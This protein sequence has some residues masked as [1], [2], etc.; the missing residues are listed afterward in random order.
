MILGKVRRHELLRC[1][2][3]SSEM[4]T[5]RKMKRSMA[6][7]DSLIPFYSVLPILGGRRPNTVILTVGSPPIY[8][9]IY[10]STENYIKFA[11]K[12]GKS[13]LSQ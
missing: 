4:W 2:F 1:S 12:C 5:A 10:I 13:A 9:Y 7:V 8:I 6:G 3:L 11:R